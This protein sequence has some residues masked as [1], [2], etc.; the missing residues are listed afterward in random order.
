MSSAADPQLPFRE[1]LVGSGQVLPVGGG[2]R[3]LGLLG[4]GAFGE[5]W[6][7]EAPGGV[8]VAVKIIRRAV[9]QEEARREEEALRLIK[10]LRHQNLLSLQA[11]FSLEDQLLI[12]AELA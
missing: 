4:R 11:F 9:K 6:R 7:A 1:T 10:Q 3:L 8:L 12:V 5:V 2:Y